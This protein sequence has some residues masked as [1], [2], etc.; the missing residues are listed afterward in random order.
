MLREQAGRPGR[1]HSPQ[2]EQRPFSAPGRR[3]RPRS[4]ARAARPGSCGPSSGSAR[5][6]G[7]SP[8]R[9]PGAGRAPGGRGR[10]RS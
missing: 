9:R 3:G 8:P 10:R 2:G 5:G 1:G 4:G 6:A 7:A